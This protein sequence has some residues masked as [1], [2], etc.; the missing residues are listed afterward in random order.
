MPLPYAGAGPARVTGRPDVLGW[1]YPAPERRTKPA[2]DRAGLTLRLDIRRRS[3][4]R[5]KA[6]HRHRVPIRSPEPGTA[7]ARNSRGAAQRRQAAA[8]RGGHPAA[9]GFDAT[10]YNPAATSAIPASRS[11]PTRSPRNHAANSTPATGE[12]KLKLIITLGV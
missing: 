5:G 12:T 3:G 7:F 9:R 2:P 11:G 6:R 1:R 8:R 10:R 4:G